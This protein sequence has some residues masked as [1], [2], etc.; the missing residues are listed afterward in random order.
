M[1]KIY[2]F[3]Y[4]VIFYKMSKSQLKKST[5]AE[6]LLNNCETMAMSDVVILQDK[7][8]DL[9]NDF[10]ANSEL[11][12]PND[13]QNLRHLI[14]DIT[15]EK[16][17]L[18]KNKISYAKSLADGEEILAADGDIT[19]EN[20]DDMIDLKLENVLTYSEIINP[21]EKDERKYK[22]VQHTFSTPS[23]YTFN[24]EDYFVTGR[25][26]RKTLEK[27]INTNMHLI[28]KLID[29][30][31]N[32]SS[33]GGDCGGSN[34]NAKINLVL[35][36]ILLEIRELNITIFN[37]QIYPWAEAALSV[38]CRLI[39]ENEIEDNFRI[40]RQMT[41]VEI[42][43]DLSNDIKKMY[44]AKDY[45]KLVNQLMLINRIVYPNFAI[46]MLLAI[47]SE[48]YVIFLEITSKIEL[49]TLVLH[50][51]CSIIQKILYSNS[52]YE[53]AL[54]NILCERRTLKCHVLEKKIYSMLS[55]NRECCA[56][57]P[58]AFLKCNSTQAYSTDKM[59]SLYSTW[60]SQ[61]NI[62]YKVLKSFI[63]QLHVAV[64]KRQIINS[65]NN[66]HDMDFCVTQIIPYVLTFNNERIE[67]LKYYT[68]DIINEKSKMLDN[69]IKQYIMKFIKEYDG[70]FSHIV[71][72]NPEPGMFVSLNDFGT[73]KFALKTQIMDLINTGY[74]SKIFNVA[75]SFKY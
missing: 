21:E 26:K 71:W 3:Y 57:F 13:K 45:N 24:K 9:L 64:D 20:P 48:F 62:H 43:S 44:A 51:F 11:P 73:G 19:C 33:N 50:I 61:A 34:L 65:T 27:I 47:M 58:S 30:D 2:F 68:L 14:G 1:K 42:I 7:M 74:I 4:K 25:M 28:H 63:R 31:V 41:K 12:E 39:D 36:D 75:K 60:K 6:S 55:N 37:E 69:D 40:F 54:S 22:Y 70:L 17:R 46:N 35:K 56:L 66:E 59:K 67:R 32:S 18:E 16:I 72:P 49:D 5:S 29:F 38:F 8:Q 10:S 15:R 52:G 23:K 53:M